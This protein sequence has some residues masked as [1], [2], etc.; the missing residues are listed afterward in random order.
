[1]IVPFVCSSNGGI[2]SIRFLMEDSVFGG[3]NMCEF[4]RSASKLPPE[5]SSSSYQNVRM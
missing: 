3:T 4:C 1:M 2:Q 5:P